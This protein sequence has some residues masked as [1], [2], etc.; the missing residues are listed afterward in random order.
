MTAE[1]VRDDDPERQGFDPSWRSF[2]AVQ[3]GLVAGHALQA[4]ADRVAGTP[5][6]LTTHFLGPLVPGA[7]F[8]TEVLPD[9]TAGTSSYRVEVR[10]GGALVALAQGVSVRPRSD[11]DRGPT[12][13]YGAPGAAADLAEPVGTPGAG[14]PF[15][16]PVELVPVSQH[17]EMRMLDDRRPAS[18]GEP[19]L[20]AWVRVRPASARWTPLVQ[21]CL[22]ADAL[23]RPPSSCWRSPS[24]C[25]PSSSP[26]T[27]RA[28]R[29]RPAPGCGS[30]SG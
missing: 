15:A 18:G 4:A 28:H 19:E 11:E 16:P 1:P 17:L 8:D 26:S 23:P 27:S 13:T 29:R 2:A 9:R 20:N 25:R 12:R 3:G 6:A 7:P 10:Q 30:G 24:G 22:L 5:R 14:E 21:L